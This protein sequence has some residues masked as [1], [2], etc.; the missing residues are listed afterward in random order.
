[1]LNGFFL[2]TE[3]FKNVVANKLQSIKQQKRF[4]KLSQNDLLL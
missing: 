4:D 3:S 1:M 2:T